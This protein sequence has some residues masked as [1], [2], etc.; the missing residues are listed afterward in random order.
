MWRGYSF[1]SVRL[2]LRPDTCPPIKPV[3]DSFDIRVLV[4]CEVAELVAEL[5]ALVEYDGVVPIPG[6]SSDQ[7]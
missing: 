4:E 1:L 5:A 3:C 6:I 7:Y 2:L